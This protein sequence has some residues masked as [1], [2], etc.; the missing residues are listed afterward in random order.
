MNQYEHPKSDKVIIA[1]SLDGVGRS[2]LERYLTHALCLEGEAT[3]RFNGNEFAFRQGD[4]LITRK[5]ELIE[6]IVPSPDF[7]VK[8]IYIEKGLIEL[9]TPNTNYGMRGTLALFL[10]PVMRL[11]ECQF[12]LCKENFRNVEV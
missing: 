9:A 12:N 8:V 11:T 7:K 6:D 1:D 3:F 10:N 4:L 5:G 2:S